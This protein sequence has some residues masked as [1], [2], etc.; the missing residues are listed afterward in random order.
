MAEKLL[1]LPI[2]TQDLAIFKK[3]NSSQKRQNSRLRG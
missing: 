3:R 1:E 2:G